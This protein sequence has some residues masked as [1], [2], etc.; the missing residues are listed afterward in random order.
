MWLNKAGIRWWPLVTETSS[1]TS[2]KSH[3]LPSSTSVKWNNRTASFLRINLNDLF[4]S[5][6]YISIKPI[7]FKTFLGIP[8]GEGRATLSVSNRNEWDVFLCHLHVRGTCATGEFGAR[9]EISGYHMTAL[10]CSTLKCFVCQK[11]LRISYEIKPEE[12]HIIPGRNVKKKRT[13]V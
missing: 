2:G 3:T 6:D 10:L 5:K 9:T 13:R 7:Y 11:H 12:Q 4:V 8:C 1:A